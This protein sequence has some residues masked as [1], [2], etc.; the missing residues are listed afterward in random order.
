MTIGT[1]FFRIMHDG[2]DEDR[3]GVLVFQDGQ[4]RNT[5]IIQLF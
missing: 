3:T 2:Q 1:R 4:D 5:E